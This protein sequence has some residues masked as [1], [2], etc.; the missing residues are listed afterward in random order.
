MVRPLLR[1]EQPHWHSLGGSALSEQLSRLLRRI[2]REGGI[3]KDEFDIGPAAP[4]EL[5][6]V[7]QD[8][9]VGVAGDVQLLDENAIRNALSPSATAWLRE[10]RV[11]LAVDSTNSRMVAAA[12]SASVD[13]CVWLAELQTAGRGRRGRRWLTPFARNIALTL[14]F[15]INQPPPQL[16]GLSLAVGLA[17]A[18]L[19]QR[20]GVS[21]AAVKWPN[22]V[23]IGD[24]KVGG[25][26]IEVVTRA[27]ATDCIIG[28][29]LNLDLPASARAGI[30]QKVTDLK[31]QGIT[32]S[33]NLFAAALV[34]AV[35]DAVNR[36]KQEGF[37]PMRPAYDALHLCHGKQVNIV[38]GNQTHTGQALGVTA[39]GALRIRID[40]KITE[41]TGG[42][43][44]L[45]PAS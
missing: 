7:V 43:V 40:G 18:G 17:A 1:P 2:V 26:L 21:D 31:A 39:A 45:R 19:L 20:E 30:D 28:I 37:A 29:G 42:E 24:A 16:G 38:Q 25:V 3:P 5:G 8:G 44:S 6:L 4:E 35:V 23:Y 41:F 10:L 27:K 12:Q 14:G 32:P 34:S 22:D 33:R 9:A 36:F 15:A 11:F 13:G